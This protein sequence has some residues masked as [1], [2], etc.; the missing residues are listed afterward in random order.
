MSFSNNDN[1]N[2]NQNDDEYVEEYETISFLTSE[3]RNIYIASLDE[4]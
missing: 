3:K 1:N 2:N 4:E